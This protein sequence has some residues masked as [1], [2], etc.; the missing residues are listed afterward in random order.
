[1]QRP[2]PA[3][4]IR[5]CGAL[6]CTALL[7]ACAATPARQHFLLQASTPEAWREPQ[8]VTS[9]LG[10]GPVQV[11]DYLSRTAM[12]VQRA[13]GS[14]WLSTRQLWAEPLPDG[15]ARVIGLNLT[16]ADAGSG[17][18][19]FPWRADQKPELSLRLRVHNLS[20]NGDQLW[21]TADWSL[22]RAGEPVLQRHFHQPAPAREDA[23]AISRALSQL[24][25]Q[26]A[27]DIQPAISSTTRRA[28]SMAPS[29]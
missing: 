4:L 13:D 15:I 24:L 26:L 16:G 9:L 7:A 18:L 28:A 2:T 22:W 27:A 10:I 1:M 17:F 3:T 5:L 25:N 8:P 21:L 11:A 23:A 29:T 19:L 12:T 20:L 6:L 14:L